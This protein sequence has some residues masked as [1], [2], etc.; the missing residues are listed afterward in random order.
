[1]R[2]RRKKSIASWRNT[3]LSQVIW[4]QPARQPARQLRLLRDLCSNLT[5]WIRRHRHGTINQVATWKTRKLGFSL[6]DKNSKVFAEVRSARASWNLLILSEW[7]QLIILLQGVTNPGEI[8]DYF[9]KNYQ[10]KIGFLRETRI[11]NVRDMEELQ[12]SH[13]LKEDELSRRKLT[14]DPNTIMEL[15]AQIQELQNE[16]NCMNDSRDFKDAESVRSVPSHVP[17]Q[18]ALLPPCRDPGGLQSRNNQPPDIWNSQG[19]SGNVFANP[20]ASSSSPYPQGFNP[21][22]SNATEDTLVTHKYGATRYMWWTSDSRHS[23]NSEISARTVSRKFIRPQGGKIL[24]EL[25]GRPTKTAALGTSLWQIP[26]SN[27]ICLLEDEIQNWGVYL[28]TIS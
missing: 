21:R 8:N 22:I 26:Y 15:R 13:V 20:P 16:V 25:W 17:S 10:D 14:E 28:F 12:K 11:R 9:K 7:R 24:K 4:A 23:L 19:I 6:K 3:T 2:T 1:M 5:E 18:P 27:N